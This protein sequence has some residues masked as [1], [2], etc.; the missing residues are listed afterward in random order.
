M[1]EAR[2][3]EVLSGDLPETTGRFL[4]SLCA[5][6]TDCEVLDLSTTKDAALWLAA[7]VRILGGRVLTYAD[8]PD[9]GLGEFVARAEGDPAEIADVFDV[10]YLDSDH[11]ALFAAA[12]RK[13]EPGALV[14][15]GGAP[16]E[17]AAA[18]QADPTCISVTVPLD[19]GLELTSV[20]TDALD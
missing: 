20:L 5:H 12:R 3:R 16:A 1:L 2:I 13:L 18:R 9:I 6:A 14:V 19:G 11:E 7:A 17:Y 10:V 4:Y 15:A 8:V